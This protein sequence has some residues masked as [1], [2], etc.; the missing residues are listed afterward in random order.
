MALKS[1]FFDRLA[2]VITLKRRTDRIEKFKAGFA[3][4]KT[5]FQLEIMNAID[6]GI[7]PSPT[8]WKSG[9][10]AWG[11]YR[12]HLRLIESAINDSRDGILIF[13][14]DA[15]F[16]TEETL[17]ESWL[18]Y[19]NSCMNELPG[20]WGMLYLGGQHQR[21]NERSVLSF[22]DHLHAAYSVNRT[23]GYAI[24]K[25]ALNVVY[26]H[27]LSRDWRQRNHIDHH[28]EELHRSGKIKV[29]ST[30]K[31][32]VFQDAG[33]SDI[34]NGKVEPLRT[35]QIDLPPSENCT[36]FDG[37][38]IVW[39]AVGWGRIGSGGE[40][41]YESKRV[42]V[43]SRTDPN[44]EWISAH[45]TSKIR[46]KTDKK[47]S[48]FGAV[49]ETGKPRAEINFSVDNIHVGSVTPPDLEPTKAIE[50]NPGTH[51]LEINTS[52]NRMAHT[53]WGFKLL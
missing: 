6:G 21:Q 10:G 31:W 19:F 7:V 12:S 5:P 36:I 24:S 33:K 18:D 25:N 11:C 14:D 39:S 22:S 13:E 15:V 4:L 38:S 20:D 41:G 48:V 28:L 32:L 40:L 34:N 53:V 17:G 29:F 46:I 49:N 45:A 52:N 23:H 35:W 16:S 9:S 2:H 26:L 3:E 42:S 1:H 43:P 51:I 30:A 50:L 44:V 8:Y 27:L 47:I 37:V